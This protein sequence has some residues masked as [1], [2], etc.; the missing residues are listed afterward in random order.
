LNK[1]FLNN[2]LLI[3]SV[4]IFAHAVQKKIKTKK[5]YAFETSMNKGFAK[6]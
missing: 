2:D 5:V 3:S 1:Y 6:V 4:E